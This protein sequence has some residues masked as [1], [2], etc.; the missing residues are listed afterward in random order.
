MRYFFLCILLLLTGLSFPVLSQDEQPRSGRFALTHASIYTVTNGIIEDG[1]VL[2]SDGKIAAV[3]KSVT[4]PSD[5]EQI[6]CTGLRI[7][8]GFIDSG[9]LLGLTEI[10]NNQRTQDYNEV[11]DITPHVKALTAVNPGS[12]LIPVTRVSGVTTVLTVPVGRLFSG[13]AALIDLFG[14]TPKQM[15]AGFEGVVLQFPAA[16]RRNAFDNKM[17]MELTNDQARLQQRV[18]ETWDK[19]IQYANLSADERNRLKHYPEMEALLPVVRGEM[20]MLIE[21]NYA[22]DIR[23]MIK[24]VARR[25]IKNVI[26]TGV[27][28]GW[29]VAPEIAA[30]GIPVIAGPVL[31][32]PSRSY[33]RYDK[34]YANPG[35]MRKAGVTVA[36]RTADSENA[37]NLPYHAGFAA[38][39]GLGKEEAL[40]AITIVPARMFGVD[41]RLGSVEQGK[42][43][44]I[45]VADGDPFEP[46]TQVK[47][48]FISGYKIPLT[49]KQTEFYEEFLSR[50]PGPKK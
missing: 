48:L 1:T 5:A 9:T 7:Y 28:E 41:D 39:Y 8:P 38:T 46:A 10:G 3:G 17:E 14:Y 27:A 6:D 30:A 49:S 35:L 32:F 18:D 15:Y 23:Y 21:V 4:I 24:W 36:L 31:N 2:I 37:R 45:F 20:P 47:H 19:A 25:K 40:K 11:G 44:N 16:G 50:D 42:V 34:A 33:D 12:E 26:F 43:A 22:A 13:T 29:R